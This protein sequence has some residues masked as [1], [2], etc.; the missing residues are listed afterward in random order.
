MPTAQDRVPGDEPDRVNDSRTD[1]VATAGTDADAAPDLT[2]LTL[3]EL[4]EHRRALV[5]ESA[6]A[7]Y[8]RRLLRARLDLLVASRSMPDP[9]TRPCA[10][11]PEPPDRDQLR[12]LV[13]APE[14]E[15]VDL[16]RALDA[17]SRALGSYRA[18]VVAATDA[19]TSELVE[20]YAAAPVDCLPPAV[21]G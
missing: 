21:A 5:A 3:A 14:C 20:R 8:W 15:V 13:E 9:L 12:M 17:A 4:R 1:A 7:S 10:A 19:A 2:T 11:L 18:E 6:R 16:L